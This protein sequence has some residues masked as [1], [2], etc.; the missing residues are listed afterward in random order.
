MSAPRTTRRADRIALVEAGKAYHAAKLAH[1]Y[2]GATTLDGDAINALKKAR[3][4]ALYA[5]ECYS[6][7]RR[8]ASIEYGQKHYVRTVA[9]RN[10]TFNK[11]K[12][13]A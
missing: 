1:Y 9:K 13:A 10:P 3:A 11:R 2:G 8:K 12:V 4:D 6:V 5:V 7:G